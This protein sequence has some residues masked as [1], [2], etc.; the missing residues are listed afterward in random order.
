M[1]RLFLI[2]SIALLCTASITQAQII[3]IA[4]LDGSQEVPAVTTGATGT[5]VLAIDPKARTVG[6]WLTY[7]GLEGQYS[8]AHFHLGLPGVSG[9]V[10]FPIDMGTPS[11]PTVRAGIANVPDSIIE[12]LIHGE[13]YINVHSTIHPTGE[14]RGQ[15]TLSTNPTWF[16]ALAGD[17]CVPPILTGGMGTA[18]ATFDGATGKMHYRATVNGISALTAAHFHYGKD[19][20]NGPVAIP[21]TFTKGT[22]DGESTIPDSALARMVRN[23]IYMNIHTTDHPNGEIRGQMNLVSALWGTADM[24]GNNQ[25]PPVQTAAT[26]V[27]LVNYNQLTDT[28]VCYYFYDVLKGDFEAAHV[29]YAPAGQNGNV[30][31]PLGA[32][33]SGTTGGGLPDSVVAGFLRG[34]LYINVHTTEHESGELRGQFRYAP[35][36]FFNFL[37]GAAEVPPVTTLSYGFGY[38]SYYPATRSLKYAVLAVGLADISAAHFHKGFPGVSGPVLHEMSFTNSLAVGTWNV[39]RAN[40]TD[41]LRTGTYMNVHSTQHPTGEIRGQLLYYGQTIDT[42]SATG[43]EERTPVLPAVAHIS[44]SPNPATGA[45]TL[46]I[47]PQSGATGAAHIRIY[48]AAMNEI[49][50]FEA[51]LDGS[52]VFTMPLDITELPSGAYFVSVSGTGWSSATPFMVRK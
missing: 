3:L 20:V 50:R 51:T 35:F 6:Y 25:T 23:S 39:P 42:A 4:S 18:W 34:K 44:V 11:E 52:A 40:F 24:N 41:L 12:H 43:V 32:Q 1:K 21:L 9:K 29:H 16:G 36:L 13:M 2:A 31:L 15:I 37:G 45:A 49:R 17:Y 48:N 46:A 47:T 8:D 27:A 10:I 38:G 7:A 5:A 19:S 28:L 26:G 30:I 14:I 33:G 22:T